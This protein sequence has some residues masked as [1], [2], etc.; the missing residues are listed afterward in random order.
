MAITNAYNNNTM[1][2]D[3]LETVPQEPITKL[4]AT[5]MTMTITS[6]LKKSYTKKTTHPQICPM[7]I[8]QTDLKLHWFTPSM[9]SSKDTS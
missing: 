4:T 6:T 9:P 8:P 3:I 5:T 2:S 7:I 1:L